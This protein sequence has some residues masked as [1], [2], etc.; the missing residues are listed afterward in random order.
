MT[1]ILELYKR[2][3]R[4]GHPRDL[5]LIADALPAI[6]D[7]VLDAVAKDLYLGE[8]GRFMLGILQ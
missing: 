6:P 1:R 8:G 5:F 3:K 7:R 2:Y 4:T